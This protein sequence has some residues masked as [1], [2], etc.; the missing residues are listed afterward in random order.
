MD[1]DLLDL[2]MYV[3]E[4]FCFDVLLRSETVLVRRKASM[5]H[6]ENNGTGLGFDDYRERILSRSHK[7]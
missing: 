6:F 5:K 2:G 4:Y 3:M 7:E 1:S